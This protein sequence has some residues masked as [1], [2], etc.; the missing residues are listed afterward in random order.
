[1]SMQV[2]LLLTDEILSK[3]CNYIINWL[4]QQQYHLWIS[5]GSV[6]TSF[7]VWWKFL[8][9]LV[10]N[11]ILFPAVKEFENRLTFGKVIAKI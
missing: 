1:M 2:C 5:Q 4:N 6:A 10:E 8:Q 3:C 9:R 11:F 7:K